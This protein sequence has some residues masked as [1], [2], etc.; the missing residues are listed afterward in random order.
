MLLSSSQVSALITTFIIISCTTA[1][2][3]SGYVLQQ[4]TVSQLRAA[5]RQHPLNPSPRPNLPDRFRST[6]T[7]LEDGTI[8]VLESEAH[9]EANQRDPVVVEVRPSVPDPASAPA[10]QQKVLAPSPHDELAAELRAARTSLE[11]AREMSERERNVRLLSEKNQLN[12]DPSAE[13][14]KP[15]SLAQR[16]RLIKEE[17]FRLSHD[18]KPVHY[19]RRLH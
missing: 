1:L 10:R 16:R 7:E 5:I 14:Q 4:R 9:A 11:A 13:D 19:Q 15:I 2:F 12:P 17:L 3:L 6:T 8:I 18:D